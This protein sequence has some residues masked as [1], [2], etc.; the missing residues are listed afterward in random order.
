V[1]ITT[2]ISSGGWKFQCSTV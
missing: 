2:K 1:D